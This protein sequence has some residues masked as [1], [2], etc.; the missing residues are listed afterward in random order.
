[1]RS[2]LLSPQCGQV[3][4]DSRIA[5]IM[6]LLPYRRRKAGVGRGLGQQ[7]DIDTHWKILSIEQRGI[8]GKRQQ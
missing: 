6:V 8:Q 7:Y 3:N 1:M 5:S 2:C 4:I